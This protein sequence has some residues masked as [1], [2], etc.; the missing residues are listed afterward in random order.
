MSNQDVATS[1]ANNHGDD[2]KNSSDS[3]SSDYEEYA[4]DFT[5]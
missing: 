5:L 2:G 3:D 1:E 4:N